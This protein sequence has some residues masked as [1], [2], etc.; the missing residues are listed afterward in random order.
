M[1][2]QHII[3]S[4][5]SLHIQL[6][7]PAEFIGCQEAEVIVLPIQGSAS[8]QESWKQWVISMAGTLNDDFPDDITDDDLGI[9]AP[10]DSLE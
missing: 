3:K 5:D 1:Y 7:L 8:S 10:R 9:D 4:P 2:T 6:D